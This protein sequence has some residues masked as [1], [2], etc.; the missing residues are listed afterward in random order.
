[1][2]WKTTLAVALAVAFFVALWGP[3][4]IRMWADALGACHV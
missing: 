3:L 4:L 2:N 1:M